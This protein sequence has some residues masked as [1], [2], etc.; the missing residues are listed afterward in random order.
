MR[1]FSI[2]LAIYSFLFSGV[3]G[4]LSPAA[5]QP[6]IFVEDPLHNYGPLY[7]EDQSTIGH[8]FVVQ[9]L[10]DETLEIRGVDPS[11]GCT[12]AEISRNE[13]PPGE[14]AQLY[15]E[16]QFKRQIGGERIRVTVGS[17]DPNH[18]SLD[19]GLTGELIR[20]WYLF[21]NRINAGIMSGSDTHTEVVT[22]TSHHLSE[23]SAKRVTGIVVENPNVKV[24]PLKDPQVESKE[25]YWEVRRVYEVSVQTGDSVAAN[26]SAR[27]VFVTD[28]PDRPEIL[29]PIEWVAEGDLTFDPRSLSL[30][31]DRHRRFAGETLRTPKGKTVNLPGNRGR[32]AILSRSGENFKIAN[33]EL[34]E[35]FEVVWNPDRNDPVASI[36]VLLPEVESGYYDQ[37]MIVTTNR[38][39]EAPLRIPIHGEIQGRQPLF[40]APSTLGHFGPLF[41][42]EVPEVS[43]T[44]EIRN[45]GSRDLELAIA[46]TQGATA[47]IEN[48]TL[49][50]GGATQLK[51]SVTF[52]DRVGE[53]RPSVTVVSNDP[54]SVRKTFEM[55]GLVLPRWTIEPEL[56][57]FGSVLEGV[58]EKRTLTVWQ[59]VH[60]WET[61]AKMNEPPT[62]ADGVRIETVGSKVEYEVS[63]YGVGKTEL[64]VHLKPNGAPG[65][66]TRELVLD[67]ESQFPVPALRIPI[68]WEILGDIRTRPN[69]ILIDSTAEGTSRKRGFRI[70]SKEKTPFSISQIVTPDGVKL[71]ETESRP[72][73][74]RYEVEWAAS[75]P[76]TEPGEMEIVFKTDREDQP[77]VRVPVVVTDLQTG[78]SSVS[79]G[80]R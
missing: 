4:I 80:N 62:G 30:K 12:K 70:Y 75:N 59:H 13:I 19:L 11:C 18:P 73:E 69:R 38:E 39:G 17:N 28:D 50:P 21:P 65:S 61:P 37:E 48:A 45:S 49:P 40:S 14:T 46:E 55:G 6:A 33:V 47:E 52:G 35:P 54:Q 8:T 26:A 78:S 43:H 31:L 66:H 2:Q 63:D 76:G 24:E 27:A 44:F 68:E 5:A 34:G 20:R 51:M 79:D 3:G 1:S 16:L 71:K 7:R 53:L 41:A 60:S 15:A 56:L 32:I 64:V 74:Y 23:A 58:E 10:G 57:R 22:L 9:N 67:V 25:G 72:G 77:S 42:D 29:L 36:E